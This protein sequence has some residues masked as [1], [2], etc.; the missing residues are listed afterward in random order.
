MAEP[1]ER[2]AHERPSKRVCDLCDAEGSTFLCCSLACLSEHIAN[3]H[4]WP[5]HENSALRALAHARQANQRL[6]DSWDGDAGHREHLTSLLT[7]L[8][9]GGE[10]CVL[11]AGNGNEL[12]LQRLA[13]HFGT[14]HLVDLDKEALELARDRQLAATREKIVL[15]GE[16]D[17]S[18][19]LPQLDAWGESFPDRAALGRA[20]LSAAQGL[21]RELGQSFPAVISNCV[22]G[23][24]ALPFQRAWITSRANWGDLLSTLDTIHLG[25]LAG[26][27]RPG[28]QALLV[29]DVASSQR[30]PALV[31]LR[32]R[33]GEELQEFVNEARAASGLALRPDPSDLARQLSAPGLSGLVSELR[34]SSPWLWSRDTDTRLV[35][36]LSFTHPAG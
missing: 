27:T 35:Y 23:G 9:A 28:G 24:L 20:A 12:D 16:L 30:T 7:A 22:L 25:T 34:L 31:E 19:V 1:S 10:L 32:G 36:G 2:C 5:E 21:V 13:E 8:P 11:G 15:H 14:I 17:L 33:S 6:P 29:V 18:G 26:A 3:A 4:G